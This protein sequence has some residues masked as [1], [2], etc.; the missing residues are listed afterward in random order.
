M[1]GK[2]HLVLAILVGALAACSEPSAPPAAPPVLERGQL[3]TL[4]WAPGEAP[5][6][7][8]VSRAAS[9]ELS[10]ME[11]LPAAPPAPTEISDSVVTFWAYTDRD[12]SVQ[13]NYLAPDS[14]WKPYVKFSV[15]AGSLSRRP[16]GSD[17]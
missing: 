1:N 14:S 8:S 7:F 13:V 16:D 15:P 5:R 12:A 10:S 9:S 6:Q 2:K 4:R 11:G 3:H 17:F